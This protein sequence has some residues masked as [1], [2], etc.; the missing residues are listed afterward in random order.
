MRIY[1]IFVHQFQGHLE[2]KSF[3]DPNY[4]VHVETNSHEQTK[5]PFWKAQ[6][7]IAAD[8][9]Y[10]V[11]V[12]DSL[13]TVVKRFLTESSH[14]KEA[15]FAVTRRNHKTFSLFLE[16]LMTHKI[17]CSYLLESCE[18]LN[19]VFRCKF[20]QDLGDVQ[21]ARLYVSE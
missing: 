20:S 18:N 11:N 14:V 12:I 21:I 2:W 19:K 1:L 6:V 9:I 4:K 3:A 17:C 13:V 8:V 15:I 7:L 5:H 16:H 10:D